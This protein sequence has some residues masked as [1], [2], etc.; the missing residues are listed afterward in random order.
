MPLT[1]GRLF[2]SPS[3]LPTAGLFTTFLYVCCSVHA[4]GTPISKL[5]RDYAFAPLFV[6]VQRGSLL[7]KCS[8]IDAR[9][10]ARDHGSRA[11]MVSEDKETCVT[12]NVEQLSIC[13]A[14]FDCIY[15]QGQAAA[16]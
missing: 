3:G 7:V 6:R 2:E 16:T 8:D 4:A 15:S 13:D 14:L 11:H 12:E 10:A 5:G 1:Q 9:T